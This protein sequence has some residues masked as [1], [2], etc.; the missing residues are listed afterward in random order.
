MRAGR[1]NKRIDIQQPVEN[2]NEYG[3]KTISWVKCCRVW[4]RV[5]PLRGKEFFAAQQTNNENILKIT[6]A[7]QADIS[8]KFRVAYHCKTYEIRNIINVEEKNVDL[9]LMCSEIT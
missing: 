7:Y 5:A 9:E 3:E 4:A 2:V 6:M 8:D 1:K